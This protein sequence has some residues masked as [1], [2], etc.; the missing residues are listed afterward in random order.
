MDFSK[1]VLSKRDISL[2][3]DVRDGIATYADPGID[4]LIKLGLV[5][6]DF[7]IQSSYEPNN[8]NQTISL[9]DNGITYLVYVEN[10]NADRR[11]EYRHD[12]MLA[13]FSVIGGALLSDPLWSFINWFANCLSKLF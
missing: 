10:T 3:K 11:R 13:I 7:V 1:I 9:T 5:T 2:L 6:T 8:T 12:W 4:N